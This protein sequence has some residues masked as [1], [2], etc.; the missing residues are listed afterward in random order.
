MSKE[1]E[2]FNGICCNT[3]QNYPDYA[4]QRKIVINALKKYELMKQ[5]KVIVADK[6]VSDEDLEK[7]KNQRMFVGSLE[8]CEIKSLFDEKK[9]KELL[10]TIEKKQKSA[11]N[12]L[13]GNH[14][15]DKRERLKGEIEAY[16]DIV[17]LIKFKYG[18]E[19]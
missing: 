8:K 3:N 4:K 6:K 7:L 15:L 2:A 12:Q 13:L 10:T 5:T 1:L 17:C 18:I 11:E 19:E 9:L 16:Y 14:D